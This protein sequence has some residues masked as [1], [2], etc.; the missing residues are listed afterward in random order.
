[1]KRRATLIYEDKALYPD[2][3]IMEMRIWRLPA[4]DSERPHGLKY[5]LYFGRSGVRLVGYDNERG[6]GDHRHYGTVETAY[7]FINVEQLIAD[8]LAD[9][10]RLRQTP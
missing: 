8:F 3:A 4:T 5:S 7:T 6:K 2:G 9:V 10:Q 1:L